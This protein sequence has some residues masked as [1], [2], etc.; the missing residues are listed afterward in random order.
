MLAREERCNI[1]KKCFDFIP[2]RAELD[3]CGWAEIDIF[4]H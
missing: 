3:L 2:L 1:A 4:E